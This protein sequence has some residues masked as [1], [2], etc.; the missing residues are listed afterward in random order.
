MANV[1]QRGHRTGRRIIVRGIFT[2]GLAGCVADQS[3]LRPGGQQAEAVA[4]LFFLMTAAGAVIWAIVMGVLIYAVLAP[5]RPRSERFADRFILIGGV[6]FP[7]LTLAG[8]LVVGLR[9]LPANPPPAGAIQVKVRAEQFWWRVSYAIEDGG[10]VE[11]ANAINLPS[12]VAVE[13]LLDSPDVI[14]S[15]WIPALGGKMDMIPGRTN[16]LV[17]NP[18][19]PGRYRGVCA[20]FCGTAHAQMAFDVE[21]QRSGEFYAWLE[22]EA[23]PAR[24]DPAGEDA[25]RRAGCPA[26]HTVRGRVEA[27]G[28]IGPDLTHFA[29]RKT[30]AAGTAANTEEALRAWLADPDAVKPG[31]RMPGYAMLPSDEM[32]A[33]VAMLRG[34]E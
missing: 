10:V 33:I 8:L 2:L 14:H 15:F 34:L 32:D 9:L 5:G 29:S 6:I 4:D 1:G 26:C 21:V 11:T 25:F 19:T 31:A 13:F 12:D 27:G 18:E 20:E 17:L 3:A 30:I 24:A 28:R 7:T 22:R 23:R 16:R